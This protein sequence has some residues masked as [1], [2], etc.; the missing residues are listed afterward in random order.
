MLNHVRY[1]RSKCAKTRCFPWR[2]T[3]WIGSSVSVRSRGNSC[4]SWG[5]L[6]C[7]LHQKFVVAIR[8]LLTCYVPIQT[9]VSP[10]ITSR[11]VL[12]VFSFFLC[13][14]K[15]DF[16][17][18]KKRVIVKKWFCENMYRYLKLITTAFIFSLFVTF[19]QALIFP[20]LVLK[21]QCKMNSTSFSYMSNHF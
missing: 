9:T 11:W 18:R 12:V 21:I 15:I 1:A 20:F 17:C 7:W 5:P 8:Y 3:T 2:S 16:L 14:A 4:S 10:R 19:W 6:V 13:L